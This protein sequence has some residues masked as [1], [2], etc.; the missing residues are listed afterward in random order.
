MHELYPYEA[1]A[2]AWL[3]AVKHSGEES[4]FLKLLARPEPEPDPERTARVLE[5]LDALG[6]PRPKNRHE[7]R[8]AARFLKGR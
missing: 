4:P 8:A 7:W 1:L 2:H 6:I 3:D 5:R